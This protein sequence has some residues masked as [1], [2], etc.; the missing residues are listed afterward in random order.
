[1]TTMTVMPRDHAE[2]TVDDLD[3]LPDDGLRYEHLEGILLVSPAPSRVHQR[4]AF[5]LGSSSTGRART[6]WRSSRQTLDWQP[7]DRTSLQPDVLV[8]ADR[9][10]ERTAATAWSANRPATPP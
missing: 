6:I 9:D 5:K 1:M 8:L 4:V 10:L 2:W 7:E 3:G